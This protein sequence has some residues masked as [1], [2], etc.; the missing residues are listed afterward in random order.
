MFPHAHDERAPTL[1]RLL[2]AGWLMPR[3]TLKAQASNQFVQMLDDVVG[4]NGTGTRDY[5]LCSNC[6][7]C[8]CDD[9]RPMN[10][11]GGPGAFNRHRRNSS[12]CRNAMCWV[13]SQV[14]MERIKQLCCVPRNEMVEWCWENHPDR[15]SNLRRNYKR[16]VRQQ[17]EAA[18]LRR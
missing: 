4:N 9:P 18:R 1:E 14:T 6:G 12:G 7:R 10:P 13:E 15:P 11:S 2:E 16:S 8:W 3:S 5:Y 17:R